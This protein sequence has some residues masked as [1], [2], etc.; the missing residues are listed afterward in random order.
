MST[1]PDQRQQS[2]ASAVEIIADAIRILRTRDGI[3]IPE[4]LVLE[5]ARNAVTGLEGAFDL[6]PTA[7][8]GQRAARRLRLFGSPPPVLQP[9]S[10]FAGAMA[11]YLVLRA[12][13][14]EA[15][16]QLDESLERFESTA[17]AARSVG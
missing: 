3:D 6:V 10:K 13:L 16:R 5:R 4:A 14:D 17:P 7:D 15:D 11:E 9:G 8:G 2:Q 12:E 1:L